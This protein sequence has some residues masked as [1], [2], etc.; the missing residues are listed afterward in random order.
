M[1]TVAVAVVGGAARAAPGAR[2]RRGSAPTAGGTAARPA[3]VAGGAVPGRRRPRARGRP[4]PAGGRG[5]GAD[6]D[7]RAAP[8]PS[9]RRSRPRRTAR[10]RRRRGRR[11]TSPGRR[12]ARRAATGSAAST[13]T[14]GSARLPTMTGWTNSTATW[15]ACSAIR[16]RRTTSWR[17]RRS[18]GRAALRGD[19]PGPSLV[20]IRTPR[21]VWSWARA[22]SAI[23]RAG[24]CQGGHEPTGDARRP[25]RLGSPCS[26]RSSTPPTTPCSATDRRWARR[27]LEPQRRAHLRAPRRGRRRASR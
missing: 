20:D 3:V 13:V 22:P 23:L 10:R 15:R 11:A 9:A 17:R 5:A 7:R 2:S 1:Q 14:A 12:A 21:S 6:P 26:K 19:R 4:T 18:A 16:A 27:R 24:R 8:T 25:V